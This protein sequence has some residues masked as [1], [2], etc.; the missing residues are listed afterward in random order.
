MIPNQTVY[1]MGKTKRAFSPCGKCGHPVKPGRKYI[2][3][4][5]NTT[6]IYHAVCFQQKYKNT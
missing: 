1:V 5:V 3:D 2:I 6:V 4:P